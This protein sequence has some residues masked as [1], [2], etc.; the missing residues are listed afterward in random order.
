MFAIPI[1]ITEGRERWIQFQVEQT[2]APTTSGSSIRWGIYDDVGWTG[3]PQCLIAEATS[4][5]ALALGTTSG[6]KNSSATLNQPLD[7]GLYWIGFKID[8][9]GTTA[10]Q[11]RA[12][13]GPNPFMPAADWV[14]GTPSKAMAWRVT[15]LSAGV[16]P[17]TFTTGGTVVGT[18]AGSCPIVG[19]KVN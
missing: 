14:A 19:F 1:A 10:S 9:L 18:A 5:G 2:N 13:N 6:M 11:L 16:L 12:C 8:A 15:G 7:P 3:Y 17:T 4:G